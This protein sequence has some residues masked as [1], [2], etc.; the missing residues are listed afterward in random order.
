MRVQDQDQRLPPHRLCDAPT[1]NPRDGTWPEPQWNP[2]ATSSNSAGE[3]NSRSISCKPFV[4][5]KTGFALACRKA[6]IVDVT[7]HTLRRTFASRL[8][9]SGVDRVAL[10]EL[11]GHS[12]IGVTMRHAHTN[13]DSKRTAVEKF[14][15]FG[16]N[17][18]TVRPNVHQSRGQ[19]CR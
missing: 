7:W 17:L 1:K 11:L 9:N 12:S 13:A 14:E 19:Y 6:R 10:K 5:L 15:G 4:D 8:V 18:A 16:N 2:S 3:I